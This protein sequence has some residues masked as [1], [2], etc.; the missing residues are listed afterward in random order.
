M[1]RPPRSTLFPY[2]TLFRS[3]TAIGMTRCA[4]TAHA[5]LDTTA[6]TH[7]LSEPYTAWAFC[8]DTS[9]SLLPEEFER[10][11]LI[12]QDTVR[13]RVEPNDLVWLVPI[14]TRAHGV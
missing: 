10:L 4:A 2:T 14:G 11:K 6:I 7:E 1:R 3:I 8:P 9:L 13:S 5:P 12:C